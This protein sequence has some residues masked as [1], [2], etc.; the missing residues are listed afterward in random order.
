M[1]NFIKN[2][3]WPSAPQSERPHQVLEQRMPET[4]EEAVEY[5]VQRIDITTVEDPYFHH[6]GGMAMRNDLGLWIKESPLHQH[7]VARFGLCHAD[8]TGAL[9]S[10]AADAA[11]NNRYYNADHDA[12]Y[13]RNYWIAQGY[14]PAT[15]EKNE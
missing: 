8:D 4:F 6:I 10:K 2:L 7:M 3:F 12:E 5:V 14:N 9:I 13:Y 11:L 1:F 15:M